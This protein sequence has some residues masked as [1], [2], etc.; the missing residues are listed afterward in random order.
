MGL[1]VWQWGFGFDYAVVF[2]DTDAQN[3][4]DLLMRVGVSYRFSM[5]IE[6]KRAKELEQL[7]MQIEEEIRNDFTV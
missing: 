2:E 1:R 7:Q 3:A 4:I 6:E 5:S